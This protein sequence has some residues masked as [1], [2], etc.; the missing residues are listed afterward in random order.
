ERQ[1]AHIEGYAKLNHH[2]VI[3]IAH[4]ADVSGAVSPFD[5]EGLGPWLCEP[6]LD[7]WQVLAVAKLDRLTRSILDFETLWKFLEAH[8]KTLVSVAEDMDYSTP[9]GRLMARQFVMFAEQER[10]M[11]RGRVKDA[12]DRAHSHGQYTGMQFPF[13]YIPVKLVPTG[14]GYEIHPVYGPTL[15]EV[16][17]R[18][19][20]GESLGSLCRCLDRHGI[21]TPRNAFPKSPTQIRPRQ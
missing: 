6:L 10:E 17:D 19:L 15:A 12:Y 7:R 16:V 18:L 1:E 4:D 14:W 21:P 5:R 2:N 13:G 11:I 20:A 3:H 8:D 9:G